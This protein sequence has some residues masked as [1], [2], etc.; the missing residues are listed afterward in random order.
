MASLWNY[1][2]YGIGY[3]FQDDNVYGMVKI[4]DKSLVC[5]QIL[6]FLHL[7]ANEKCILGGISM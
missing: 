2:D 7:V 5:S 4:V 6:E 3:L 1:L